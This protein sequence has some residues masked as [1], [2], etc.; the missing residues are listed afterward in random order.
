M[1]RLLQILNAATGRRKRR[2][3]NMEEK[4]YCVLSYR[5]ERIPIRI[6]VLRAE[7]G[8]GD[9]NIRSCDGRE[10]SHGRA[11]R[12]KRGRI[13]PPSFPPWG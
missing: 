9:M 13:Y 5:G 8:H 7:E 6:T 4:D 1:P 12:H 3:M 10:R 11:N 2:K